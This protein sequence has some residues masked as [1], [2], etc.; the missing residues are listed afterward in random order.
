MVRRREWRQL[1]WLPL[2]LVVLGILFFQIRAKND[3]PKPVVKSSEAVKKS[4]PENEKRAL[5]SRAAAPKTHLPVAH[6]A[7]PTPTPVVEV[8]KTPEVKPVEVQKQRYPQTR[9]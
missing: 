9:W 1:W 8:V 4:A 2:A 6:I 3:A 7:A 5:S